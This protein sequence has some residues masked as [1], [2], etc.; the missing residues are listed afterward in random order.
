MRLKFS[1]WQVLRVTRSDAYHQLCE[2]GV[3]HGWLT[4]AFV[5]TVII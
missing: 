4:M 2:F 3:T 1:K 5:S